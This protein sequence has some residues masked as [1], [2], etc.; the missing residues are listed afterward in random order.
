M[1]PAGLTGRTVAIWNHLWVLFLVVAPSSGCDEDPRQIQC[2]SGGC[3]DGGP[4]IAPDS[5]ILRDA[6][7]WVLRDAGR[8]AQVECSP[9]TRCVLAINYN[10]CCP[11]PLS[12][13]SS[14]VHRSPCV[15][16]AAGSPERPEGCGLGCTRPDL[17]EPCP[18]ALSA[19]CGGGQCVTMFEGDCQPDIPNSCDIGE[20][21]ELRDGVAACVD[22][23][24]TCGSDDDCPMDDWRCGDWRTGGALFCW[25][26]NS[27]CLD[28]LSCPD[29][30]ACRDD[31]RDGVYQC[32]D[33]SPLCRVGA[34]D[35]CPW[36][37][38]CVD[39]EDDG[40]GSCEDS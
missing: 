34:P 10:S 24:S 6:D 31:D 7:G 17:C 3:R 14:P 27:T 16:L 38:V 8:D 40:L 5:D 18:T 22:D 33:V 32:V 30:N 23:P 37:Q 13:L 26:P 12:T 28:D 21:C 36:G 35:D 25:H 9:T 15:L 2:S 39:A 1:T 19:T 29:N 11:C 4:I 20:I